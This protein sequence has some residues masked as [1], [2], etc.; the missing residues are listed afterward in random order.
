MKGIKGAGKR[1]CCWLLTGILLMGQG[2]SSA[3]AEEIAPPVEAEGIVSQ[4]SNASSD[5][6]APQDNNGTADQM[7]MISRAAG[8]PLPEN[9]EFNLDGLHWKVILT[10]SGHYAVQ[11]MGPEPG[12]TPRGR[13]EIP[14]EI[15]YQDFTYWVP[16]IEQGAFAGCTELTEVEL[17]KI[18]NGTFT[19]GAD[20]T[21]STGVFEG[22]TNLK[23]V[24]IPNS[25]QSM[26]TNVFRGCT[27]LESVEFKEPSDYVR[28]GPLTICSGAFENCSALREISLL[29]CTGLQLFQSDIFKD[30]TNLEKVLLPDS[31]SIISWSCF[32]GCSSLEEITLP[33][34]LKQ[35]DVNIFEGCTKLKRVKIPEGTEELKSNVFSQCS[36]LT[37]V[38]ISD[39][40]K[41][42]GKT[43]FDGCSML[44]TLKIDTN[45]PAEGAG[46]STAFVGPDYSSGTL[47]SDRKVIF[48]N[49]DGTA[50]L[51]GST[52]TD[53]KTAYRAVNDGD[54]TDD[55]WYGWEISQADAYPIGI[56][57]KKDGA[58]WADSGKS[59]QLS[60]NGT[61]FISYVPGNTNVPG[62][63]YRIYEVNGSERIDTKVD[64]TVDKDN[65]TGDAEVNYYTVTFYHDFENKVPYGADTDQKPQIVLNGTG[66]SQPA[67]PAAAEGYRFAYWM[68]E[69][70]GSRELGRFD[71]A[72]TMIAKTTDL[73][74]YWLPIYYTLELSA[75]TGGTVTPGNHINVKYGEDQ[76]V[77]ITPDRD[78]H[79]K[80]ILIDGVAVT[81]VDLAEKDSYTY[82]F[83]GVK[84]GHKVEVTFEAD[85]V[86]T[87]P[88]DPNKPGTP[89]IPEEPNKPGT[90]D[91]P[92]EV[93]K[94][95]NPGVPNTPDSNGSGTSQTPDSSAP[96]TAA[97]ATPP[98]AGGGTSG[99]NRTSGQSRDPKTGDNAPVEIYATLAMI[100]GL[101]EV[102][103]YFARNKKGMTEDKKKELV[104]S[105]VS[106]A[107]HGTGLRRYAAL[108]AIFG[109]LLYYHSIGKR[110]SAER[111]A[112]CEA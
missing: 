4:E 53:A 87:E 46:W 19:L 66:A 13:L 61:D 97:A 69:I 107:K 103:L 58:V 78:H 55:N 11:C 48:L 80:E 40:T 81:D 105:L 57:V 32:A 75:G 73:Y 41:I 60:A 45:A 106:W 74:A 63:T 98:T 100:A 17:L 33:A 23:N 9:S 54:S 91:T 7:N 28:R 109:L 35:L 15:V 96:G 76:T 36:S 95:E 31:L 37:E 50:A 38:E 27:A 99:I 26:G 65:V 71:F 29:N 101:T 8:T 2:G 12:T 111:E 104:A 77:I 49:S 84:E 67:D 18:G 112:L 56:T 62:G 82:T 34:N 110:M 93:N 5:S 72:H 51:S 59:F 22:C 102:M 39:K 10:T 70:T 16:K 1:L 89:D 79:I 21:G 47:P 30:C 52:L 20:K 108:A 44:Q 68:E 3:Y 42:T 25:C 24:M 94:P 6:T 43:I 14:T 86:V 85:S 64:V 88:E 90:S 83:S 92:E